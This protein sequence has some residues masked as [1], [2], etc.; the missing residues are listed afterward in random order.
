VLQH[1]ID[2]AFQRGEAA[3][4]AGQPA[5]QADRHHARVA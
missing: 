5:V 1:V 4:P 2:E 3:G